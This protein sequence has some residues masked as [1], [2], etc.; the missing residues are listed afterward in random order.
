MSGGISMSIHTDVPQSLLNRL[1]QVSTATVLTGLWRMG[2]ERTFMEGV[3]LLIPGRRLAA[4]ART[5]RFLPTRPDLREEVTKGPDSPVYRAMELCGPG[6]ALVIDAMRMPYAC[7]GGDV[8]FLQLKMQGADGIVSDGGIRDIGT[9]SGYGLVVYGA[10]LTP[11]VGAMDFL[12]YDWNLPIQ[13]GG[14]LVKPGDVVV[15]DEA[16]VV[17]VPAPLVE[18]IVAYAEETEQAEEFVKRLIQKEKCNPGKY[19]PL[20]DEAWRLFRESRK[21]VK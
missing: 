11:K 4:R 15:G 20:N 18:K 12:F 5:L 3:R 9:I 6:D 7:I 14:V 1:K 19:Y 8:R 17:V 13:C 16:G 2:Y 10:E 21:K